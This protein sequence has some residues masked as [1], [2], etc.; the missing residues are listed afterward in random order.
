MDS[1]LELENRLN[2]LKNEDQSLYKLFEEIYSYYYDH[3]TLKIS[4]S[5]RNLFLNY[6][7]EKD[8]S[9][10]LISNEE[11]VIGKLEDQRILNVY[12]EYTG[13]GTLYNSLRSKRPGMTGDSDSE[14]FRIQKM[15]DD[16]SVN[17][18]F[19]SPK[20]K[21][22]EDVFGR[23]EGKYSLTAANIAKYDVYSSLIIFNN[24]NPLKF[25]QKELSDYMDTGFRWFERVHSSDMKYNYPFLVWNCLS[26]AGASQIHGH[27]QIL[28]T[29]D[30]PYAKVDSF[31]KAC[32][33]Y[34]HHIGRSF[35]DDMFTVHSS[36]G[37]SENYGDVKIIA[38]ITPIKEKELMMVTSEDSDLEDVKQVIYK[39]LRCFIDVLG[40][41]SFNL[42]IS[43][44]PMDG[45][46]NQPYIIHL[47]DRG[48]IFK[49][50]ADF[51]GMELYGTT[52]V[53]DDP[54]MIM[55][56]IRKCL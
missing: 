24:H 8:S 42:A 10:N 43:P 56:S 54:C 13:Q 3:G 35:L 30:R 7:G 47:V 16:S 5:M 41:R 26:R 55:K 21:T 49:P 36:L 52:V 37:L 40:V 17:C 11:E 53:A 22:P 31:K 44:P 28:I 12:N 33:R 51:G 18:D 15:I 20:D 19:C 9:G 4:P 6:F 39:I 32:E 48:N 2:N 25:D 50:T 27:A 45:D 34:K 46:G 1:I 23:I 14:M 29:R 38:S